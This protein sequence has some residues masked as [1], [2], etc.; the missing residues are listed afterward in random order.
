MIGCATKRT[1]ASATRLSVQR[2]F[3][4]S[5]R[6]LNVPVTSPGKPVTSQAVKSDVNGVPGSKTT[7]SAG[8]PSSVKA[9]VTENNEHEVP[10]KKAFSLFG[11]LWKTA[12]L[13]SVVYGSTLYVATKNEKVMDF[14]IDKQLPYYEELVDVI[15]NGSVEDLKKTWAKLSSK[16]A[17]PSKG[18]IEELTHQ[19]EVQGGHLI[20]ETKKKLTHVQD[21]L[22][23]EQ[24]QKSVGIETVQG[25]IEKIPF[26]ALKDGVSGLADDSVKATIQSF[27]D[28]LDLVDGSN[29]G[30]KKD[31][32]VKHISENI[33]ALSSKLAALNNSF[34]AELEARL[35]DTKTQLLTA[36]TQKEL[37][38]TRSMLDQYNHEKVMLEKKYKD[39][40]S[41]EVEATR[42]ALSQAAV[43]A[44]TMVRIEQTKRF[45]AMVK[46]KIDEERDG[47]L[48]NLDALSARLEEV[49]KFAIGLEQQ[50]SSIKSK[51]FIQRASAKLKSLL[52]QTAE[53]APAQSLQPFVESLQSATSNSNDEVI[54]LALDEL[55]PLLKNE[56]TQSILTVP[57]L[58]TAWEQL[59]PELRSASLLPPNAGLLGHLASIF[60]SKLLVPV[61]G[62]KPEGKD[63]ESVIG[64]VEQSLV[65]G[66]LDSAVEEVA[67]LKGW[68]RK[69][70]DDWVREGR[71]RLE[72]EF[73]ID[74]IDAETK[75]L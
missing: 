9:R 12:L 43:N 56:S 11:L 73:L 50:V 69:L 51:T 42:K 67:N 48:K 44:T 59:T 23:S 30:P 64:R 61:K 28:L 7:G 10:K 52:T 55:K 75:V 68:T 13:A 26:V 18:Q 38:L 63:I 65:R 66:E 53:N 36:H 3:A 45:E 14:V 29:I 24:L 20:E 34:E 71:K 46:R 35:K 27:N 58:L 57:Q 31:A 8:V 21:S 39:R 60:F 1:V 40:L 62:A 33:S 22:P 32:M 6:V 74:L 15:E 47:R 41:H 2:N 4:L 16:V 49:E 5:A 17:L 19:I 54:A 25:K 72:A 70:A 37:D